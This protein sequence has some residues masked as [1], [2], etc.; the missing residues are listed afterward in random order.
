MTLKEILKLVNNV[1]DKYLI[2]KPFVVGGLP[3]DIFMDIPD[4]KTADIDLTTNSAEVLRLGLLIAE[5][6][7][8]TFE[9]AD[10]GHITVYSED[11]DLD[12]SS[13][14]ISE[15]VVEHLAGSYKGL[16]EAFSRDFTINALHQD[17]VTG[18][19]SDPTEQ[20]FQDIK[21]K[22][23][24][25]PVPPEITLTDDPRRVYRAINLAA[26]Y[27]FDISPEIKKFTIDNPE[28]FSA[29]NVKGKYIA[30]KIIK[31]LKANEDLTLSLLKEMDLLKHVPLSGYFKDVLIERKILLDHLGNAASDHKVAFQTNSWENYSSQGTE[32]KELSDWW[33]ANSSSMI[34]NRNQSYQSW[35]EWYMS[36]YKGEWGNR[37]RGPKETLISMKSEVAQPEEDWS[38]KSL[39]PSALTEGFKSRRDDLY[40]MLG[41]NGVDAPDASSSS[42]V[43][44]KP[45]VDID[46]IS[47]AAKSFISAIGKK[48]SELGAETPLITSGWRSP[49]GQAALMGRNW[50][51]N[52]GLNGG[53][54]YLVGLY[55]KDYG[56]SMSY[57]FERN[58]L[59]TEALDMA[60]QVVK[61]RAIGS[62]HITSP[63]KALDF[64]VT[65]GI[66]E[67][68]DAVAADG[69][70]NIKILDETNAA[71]PHY[72]ISIYGE[73]KRLA[74]IRDRKEQLRKLGNY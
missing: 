29:E 15:K 73:N 13:N 38:L 50:T 70:F 53:R 48:A 64:A 20:G 36:K 42:M 33:K 26:R 69:L 56:G 46:N 22:L 27:G 43:D 9:I 58:G 39:V 1:A 11:F 14:F 7:N 25:T 12:F 23:I 52:G 41:M 62:Y 54:A 2:D 49:E 66:K 5:E 21:D 6:L 40:E 24:R 16:E 4:V 31:G 47:M 32:Y 74:E 59:G 63:G 57:I 71:G 3:R 17:L 68:L 18:R 67:V 44:V 51:S 30:V 61:S 8:V 28:L 45:G 10:D 60:T 34:G 65:S 35:T 55:G 19:I 37:H 72:H